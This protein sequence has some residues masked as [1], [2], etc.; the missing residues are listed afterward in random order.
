VGE[1][2]ATFNGKEK[3]LGTLL[4]P[5]F[6][7]RFFWQTVKR[8][9]YLYSGKVLRVKCQLLVAVQLFWIEN[10]HPVLINPTASAEKQHECQS[11]ATIAAVN[12]LTSSVQLLK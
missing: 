3:V 8:I 9:I 6:K 7:H 4:A 5:S 1:I 12:S 11:V 2:T 10:T